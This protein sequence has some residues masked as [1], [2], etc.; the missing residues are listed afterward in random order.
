MGKSTKFSIRDTKTSRLRASCIKQ[1]SSVKGD[2]QWA[3]AT[4]PALKE[5]KKAPVV[6][7]TRNSTLKLEST[8]AKH[9]CALR[10]DLPARLPAR[11][12]GRRRECTKAT[13]AASPP[14]ATRSSLLRKQCI[15]ANTAARK[16][17]AAHW[18]PPLPGMRRGRHRLTEAEKAQQQQQKRASSTNRTN[19]PAWIMQLSAWLYLVIFS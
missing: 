11:V 12:H 10:R 4:L 18:A 7:Q 19:M 8:R 15:E 6:A 16:A 3:P 1:K 2:W 13:T 9:S 5:G 14:R 17:A